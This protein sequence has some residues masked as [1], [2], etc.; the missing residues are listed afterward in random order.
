MIYPSDSKP[1]ALDVHLLIQIYLFCVKLNIDSQNIWQS[2]RNDNEFELI[3]ID[4][5]TPKTKMFNLKNLEF[6]AINN[7]SSQ[8]AVDK[9][10][11][12]FV[13]FID[14]YAFFFTISFLLIRYFLFHEYI[15]ELFWQALWFSAIDRAIIISTV[16]F[17]DFVENMSL[18]NFTC[19]VTDSNT[20]INYIFLKNFTPVRKET[21]TKGR[22]NM[23]EIAVGH[24]TFASIVLLMFP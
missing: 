22:S 11:I 6:K 19:F 10:C 14:H 9:L 12:F 16:L 18:F 8:F 1:V 17:F 24:V 15:F 13:E 2:K 3:T 23:P 21:S 4:T 20:N 7:W 5:S